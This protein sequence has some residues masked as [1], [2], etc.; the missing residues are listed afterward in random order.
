[1]DD[2]SK[3]TPRITV[4][5]DL[6]DRYSYLCFLDTE[7]GEIME[8]G[9]LRTTLEA[10]TLSPWVSRVLKEGGPEVL[11]ANPRKRRGS[12]ILPSAKLMR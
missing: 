10:G 1:M 12:S 11:V 2:G 8:E 7:S 5:V 3:A 6:G 9:K 4:G